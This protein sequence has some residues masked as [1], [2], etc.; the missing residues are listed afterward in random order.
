L[1]EFQLEYLE[2][3]EKES[4]ILLSKK[5]QTYSTVFDNKNNPDLVS[6]VFVDDKYPLY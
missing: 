6:L 5:I 2:N 4:K 3:L 1:N